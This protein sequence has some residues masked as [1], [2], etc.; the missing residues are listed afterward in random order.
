MYILLMVVV[1]VVFLLSLYFVG[2]VVKK[3]RGGLI[4]CV[5]SNSRGNTQNAVPPVRFHIFPDPIKDPERFSKWRLN[6]RKVRMHW[7]HPYSLG[8][9]EP[10][11]FARTVVCSDHFDP[12]CYFPNSIRLRKTAVP[13]WSTFD[14]ST[15]PTPRSTNTSRRAATGVSFSPTTF[16]IPVMPTYLQ[17]ECPVHLP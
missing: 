13:L 5:C 11:S 4:C 12:I 10:G 7:D 17:L 14:K 8:N 1:G 6:V 3:W 2:K 15:T 9:R 16:F